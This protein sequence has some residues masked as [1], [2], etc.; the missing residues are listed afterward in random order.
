MQITSRI[1]QLKRKRWRL[2]FWAWIGIIIV[3]SEFTVFRP[4]CLSQHLLSSCCYTTSCSLQESTANDDPCLSGGK[5]NHASVVGKTRKKYLCMAVTAVNSVVS[6]RVFS[7]SSSILIFWFFN[8]R[9]NKLSYATH[10]RYED[11]TN[12]N[13]S[14]AYSNVRLWQL[15]RTPYGRVNQNDRGQR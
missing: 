10:I 1:C 11:R 13:A 4:C 7:R 5:M 2:A 9:L 3:S 14:V 8:A 15:D 6:E 12:E